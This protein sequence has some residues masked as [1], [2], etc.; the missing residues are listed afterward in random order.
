MSADRLRSLGIPA[1]RIRAF[2]IPVRIDL[3]QDVRPAPEKTGRIVLVMGVALLMTIVG[4]LAKVVGMWL[5]VLVGIPLYL[6]FLLAMM[7]VMF[8]IMY[9]VW[10]DICGDGSDADAS[11]GDVIEV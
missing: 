5:L 2:G 6:A 9:F 1:E 8:G 4:L 11:H 7:V 10:R 3:P